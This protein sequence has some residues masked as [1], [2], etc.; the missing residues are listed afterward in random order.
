[1]I[2]MVSGRREDLT[3]MLSVHAW[4]KGMKLTFVDPRWRQ[5]PVY[6]LDGKGNIIREW[7][8]VPSI[9]EVD[10]ACEQG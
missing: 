5:D 3:K 7:E 6:L 9:G 8:H 2:E 1:M 10:D 4:L